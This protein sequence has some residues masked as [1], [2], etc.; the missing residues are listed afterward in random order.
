MEN[1][2]YNGM[3]DYTLLEPTA[4]DD[5]IIDLC[6]KAKRFGVKSV[7]VLPGKVAIASKELE[8][9]RVLVCTVIS[10]PEGTNTLDQKVKETY[11][12]L[13]WGAD[14]VDM[15][16][17][18]QM[19]INPNENI[20]DV[21]EFLIEEISE[22]VNICHSV[23]N[24]ENEPV[25][26]KVIVESGALTEEQTKIAT[27]ICHEAKADFIK[28]STGKVAWGA[29]PEKVKIMHD[30]IKE[31]HSNMKIKVSGGVRT[32]AQIETFEQLG[33]SRFGMGYGAV[34]ILNGLE[35][36]NKGY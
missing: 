8:N 19:L 1:F 33:A 13:K 25:I 28:T 4:T 14:E 23:R 9:S 12:V 34:D 11:S 16:M 22:L 27:E 24:K 32:L 18:Y 35:S 15:V 36:E 3:I 20:E 17:N 7:C 30:T 31:L 21:R 10:F 2:K 29:Q 6:E 5:Q 26:L